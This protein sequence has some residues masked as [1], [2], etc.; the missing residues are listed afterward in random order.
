MLYSTEEVVA[1]TVAE[2]IDLTVLD[3]LGCF[4]TNLR[5]GER[6]ACSVGEDLHIADSE[7]SG[8]GFS[9]IG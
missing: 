5:I 1:D 9:R 7:S 6:R 4:G 2:D 3:N 8:S